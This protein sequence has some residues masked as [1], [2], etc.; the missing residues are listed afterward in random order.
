MF[1][2]EQ[3]LA[4][5]AAGASLFVL[6]YF[7]SH[8]RKMPHPPG[9]PCRPV[10]GLDPTLIPKSEPWKR[11]AEWA[12]I[13]GP[14]FS[15]HILGRRVIVLN[16][17]TEMTALLTKRAS[18][19]SERPLRT[20]YDVIM[21][22]RT[23]VFNIPASDERHRIYRR[24]L[25]GTLNKQAVQAYHPVLEDEARGML[26]RL[27][28]APEQ[29]EKHI[30][31]TSVQTIMRIT[32]GYTVK[33]EDPFVSII[34]DGF[35][36]SSIGATPGKWLVDVFPILRFIP[37][38]VPGAGFQHKGKE[39]KAL[40]DRMIEAPFTWTKGQMAAGI[41]E[42]SFVSHRCREALVEEIHIKKSAAGLY[43]GGADTVVSALTTFFLAMT[44]HPDVERKAHVELDAVVGHGCLPTCQDL[45][46]L[47]YL[48]CILQEVLRWGPVAP[49]NL[50]HSPLHSDEYEGYHIEKDAAIFAN[51]W[52]VLHDPEAYPDPETFAPDR[53]VAPAP[54]EGKTLPPSPMEYAFG[55]GKRVCPGLH[56]AE[57]SLMLNMAHIL[58][59][60]DISKARG[61]DG[62][63]IEPQVEFTTGITRPVRL[64]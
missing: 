17:L 5:A 9:P 55:F 1:T 19:C 18:N 37:S 41:A 25:N 6:Q 51:L 28:V 36:V 31:H 7:V 10:L 59:V 52:A 63:E 23:S 46:S 62:R 39:W 64:F 27:L 4:L 11:Y 12:K 61:Q 60:F 30:R 21:G 22:R 42:Y 49:L 16:S 50:P 24:L 45:S 40:L 32:Y 33:E 20:M 56:F 47:P 2:T 26:A 44:L 48:R 15:F 54:P 8:R 43:A 3:Y 34:E 53:F 35:R 29:F 57:C 58:S 13:Y 14:I 38:W